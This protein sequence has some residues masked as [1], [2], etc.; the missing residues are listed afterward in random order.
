MVN[1]RCELVSDLRMEVMRLAIDTEGCFAFGL[2][3]NNLFICM[4][5]T[6]E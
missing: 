1:P 6:K 5:R 4:G 2:C 3:P